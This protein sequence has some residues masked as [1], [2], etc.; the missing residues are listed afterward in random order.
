MRRAGIVVVLVGLLIE[1]VPRFY[2]AALTLEIIDTPDSLDGYQS[3]SKAMS[4]LQVITWFV[5]VAGLL[6]LL[7]ARSGGSRSSHTAPSYPSSP[8]S[9]YP[10]P[11]QGY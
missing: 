1:A 8:G 5:V 4:S 3:I 2:Y 9:G 7:L 6:M 11:G 10:P